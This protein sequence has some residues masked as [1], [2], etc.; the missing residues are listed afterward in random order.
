MYT[1][2]AICGAGSCFG[3]Q[4][5][6]MI[7]LPR[8]ILIET[9]E[10]SDC[11]NGDKLAFRYLIFDTT[12]RSSRPASRHTKQIASLF[13]SVMFSSRWAGGG[14]VNGTHIAAILHSP[15]ASRRYADHRCPPT[16]FF[17]TYYTNN[18]V[19]RGREMCG[20]FRKFISNVHA[21]ASATQ[22]DRKIVY[23]YI[24]LS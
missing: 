17:Q 16:P 1:Y 4:D 2:S 13:I 3:S 12:M 22:Y 11:A 18:L 6:G 20:E 14:R 5:G 23:S 10:H 7:S 24:T 15:L 21:Y 9:Q 19:S 8:I